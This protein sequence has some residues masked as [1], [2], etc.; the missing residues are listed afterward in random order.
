M[1]NGSRRGGRS[2]IVLYSLEEISIAPFRRSLIL[3]ELE[4]PRD[5]VGWTAS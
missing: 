1:G 5:Q 2:T 3:S 4:R